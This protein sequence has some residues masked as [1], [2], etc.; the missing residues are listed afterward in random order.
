MTYELR[1]NHIILF[2]DNVEIEDITKTEK[3]CDY[4]KKDVRSC[5]GNG[6]GC[7]CDWFLACIPEKT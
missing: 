1:E 3:E 4:C 6:N 2:E 7:C 5:R